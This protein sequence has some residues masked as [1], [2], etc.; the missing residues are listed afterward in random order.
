M[1]NFPWSS[2]HNR[3]FVHLLDQSYTW[4]CQHLLATLCVSGDFK[5]MVYISTNSEELILFC[6]LFIREEDQSSESHGYLFTITQTVDPQYLSKDVSNTEAQAF[7]CPRTHFERFYPLSLLLSSC[8]TLFWSVAPSD[9]VSFVRW[10][11]A[12]LVCLS[13]KVGAH[14][15][16]SMN[17]K[18]WVRRLAMC[19][20]S[21]RKIF[22]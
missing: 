15:E 13:E 20:T 9:F 14:L 7:L 2:F 1:N 18:H 12:D 5:F 17:V 6:P 16:E 4:L 3:G 11:K 21:G 22:L 8:V 10:K 19:T